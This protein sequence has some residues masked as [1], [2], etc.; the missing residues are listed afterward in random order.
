MHIELNRQS[1]IPLSRQIYQSISDRISSGL[2][3]KGSKL[4]SVRDL[5]KALKVSLVTV[6]KSYSMLQ[7]D[8]I[9]TTITGKGSYAKD[10][11]PIDIFY[12]ADDSTSLAW[13]QTINDYLPRAQFG[14]QNRYLTKDI[15][16]QMSLAHIHGNL[17]ISEQMCKSL[18]NFL[19]KHPA[20]LFEYAPVQGD[21]M[22]RSNIADYLKTKKISATKDDI[23]ITNGS[24]QSIN[25]IARTFVGPGDIVI[26]EETTYTAAI[27]VFRWQGAT[28]IS[29]PVDA[30]GINTDSLLKICYSKPP[31]LIY[32][33]PTYHNPTGSIMSLKKR[34]QLLNI[35]KDFNCLI[36]EDDPW[37]EISFENNHPLSIK[38]MDTSGHVIYI[39]GFSKFLSPACRV[40][41]L[42]ASGS[43]KNRL[44]A[45][46]SNSDLGS[47][48]LTQKMIMPFIDSVF[49]DKHLKNLNSLLLKRRNLALNLL[50]QY[51]PPTVKWTVPQGGLSIWITLP[52]STSAESL[53]CEAQNKNISFLS[54]SACY[55]TNPQ[56]NHLRIS[57]SFIDENN[58]SEGITSLCKIVSEL[59]IKK[60]CN[61]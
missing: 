42:L 15:Q 27:D 45:A 40:G 52:T 48:L 36:I 37:S 4:P 57:F 29:I 41:A 58:L 3:V 31:K 25:L 38:S 61:N 53:I 26:M 16:I 14:I 1:K 30:D 32:T 39:K 60:P 18:S 8:N 51:M 5:S 34:K 6:W 50:E 12:C 22:L 10:N 21:T 56:F 49:L 23:I 28:I 33:T 35:A 59:C 46:K 13:Q 11:N 24:Q 44:I 9:I 43:I 47:P 54:G 2:I 55:P 7:K 17:P 20:S 19:L